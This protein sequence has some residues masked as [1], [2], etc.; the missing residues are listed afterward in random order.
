[1]EV[2]A[3]GQDQGGGVVSPMGQVPR[4]AAALPR[5]TAIARRCLRN[6]VERGSPVRA[7]MRAPM[8]L[9]ISDAEGPQAPRVS[10]ATG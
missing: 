1:V 7:W 8:S 5:W 10:I 3:L 2:S 9:H 4:I 6:E